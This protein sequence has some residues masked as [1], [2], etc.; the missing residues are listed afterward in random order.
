MVRFCASKT[1][2]SPSPIS[3]L[4]TV[5]RRFIYC[6]SSLCVRL[7]FIYGVWFLLIR[8]SSLL[9]LVPRE[10]C[11]NPWYIYLY[12]CV[13][14]CPKCV[15]WRFWFFFGRTCSKIHFLTLRLIF[16]VMISLITPMQTEYSLSQRMTKPTKWH[17]R[18]AKTKLSLCICPVWSDSSL[19]AWRKLDSIATHWAHSED[20]DPTG[21]MPR[22]IWAFAGR[23]C[24]FVG[25]DIRWHH[26]AIKF[27][28]AG[29]AS[30]RLSTH[31][32]AVR[33]N[34]SK[35][36]H[37]NIKGK[38]GI[39]EQIVKSNIKR[40]CVSSESSLFDT[41]LAEFRQLAGSNIDIWNVS[42]KYSK[43]FRWPNI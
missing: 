17:V 25:F 32:G 39:S 8:S 7:L 43:D 13:L 24:H 15:A 6:S 11:A 33:L 10:G 26:Y 28:A 34:C 9:L 42:D 1:G 16:A 18:P 41:H 14:G 31:Q 4:L 23:T 12:F 35:Y 22:L 20:S 40:Y 37:V 30:S 36:G 38:Y 21:R 2:L 29:Y 3:I 27:Y 5:P 19:S